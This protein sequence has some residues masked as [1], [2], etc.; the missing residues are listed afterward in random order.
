LHL[1]YF[2]NFYLAN[3][4]LTT[5]AFCSCYTNLTEQAIQTF[6]KDSSLALLLLCFY[7]VNVVLW[8]GVRQAL[9]DSSHT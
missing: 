1:E 8:N 2:T 7:Y 9:A 6:N 4:Y 3:F 5:A